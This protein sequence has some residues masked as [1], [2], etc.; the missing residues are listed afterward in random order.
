MCKFLD[1]RKKDILHIVRYG[2]YDS[3]DPDVQEIY[4]KN[5]LKK[6]MNF[7]PANLKLIED[8]KNEV[9]EFILIN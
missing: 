7:L 1:N 3:I 4:P 2:I 8:L 6:Q 9:N 5:I